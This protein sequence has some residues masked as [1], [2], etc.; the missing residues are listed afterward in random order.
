MQG[1]KQYSER[2]FTSYFQLSE[3][4]PEDNFYRRL[5]SLLDLN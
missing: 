1:R 3:R 4:V 2:L 5:K